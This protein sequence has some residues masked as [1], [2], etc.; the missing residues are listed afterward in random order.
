MYIEIDRVNSLKISPKTETAKGAVCSKHNM[1]KK[2]LS[3]FFRQN[4]VYLIV[5]IFRFDTMK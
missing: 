3:F 4:K 1:W 5:K 2:N